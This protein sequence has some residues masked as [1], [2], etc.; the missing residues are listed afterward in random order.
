MMGARVVVVGVAG[1]GD[2]GVHGLPWSA[3]CC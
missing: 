1:C 3:V 2:G